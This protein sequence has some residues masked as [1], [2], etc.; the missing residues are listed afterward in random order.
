MSDKFDKGDV[1]RLNS[2]GPDMT[3]EYRSTG[4]GKYRCHWFVGRED[5]QIMQQA[6]FEE[7]E[8]QLVRRVKDL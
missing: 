3:I 2:G 6:E 4:N 8:L 7:A 1:V 5:Q